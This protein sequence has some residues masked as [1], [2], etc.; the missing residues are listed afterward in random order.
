MNRADAP[1]QGDAVV[2]NSPHSELKVGQIVTFEVDQVLRGRSTRWPRRGPSP[3]PVAPSLVLFVIM[4]DI[5]HADS[6]LQIP[7]L[8]RWSFAAGDAIY[9]FQREHSLRTMASHFAWE[10]VFLDDLPDWVSEI[11]DPDEL[12]AL[13]A[14]RPVRAPAPSAP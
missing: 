2:A 9:A 7:I 11:E 8:D 14:G 1:Q 12:R 10:Q 4:P 13:L 5:G 6:P 3:G